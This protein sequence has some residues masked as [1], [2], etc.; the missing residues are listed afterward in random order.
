M[1]NKGRSLISLIVI[2]LILTILCFLIY[3]IFY[4]DIL[5]IKNN[6][7]QVQTASEITNKIVVQDIEENTIQNVEKVEPI[8]NNN[9]RR[10]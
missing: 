8:I 7:E 2:I 1:M 9:L 6:N 4:V 5:A 3:E 10:K